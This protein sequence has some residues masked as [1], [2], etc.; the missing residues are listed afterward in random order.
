MIEE[1]IK[2]ASLRSSENTW[3]QVGTNKKAAFTA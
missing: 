2:L 1:T 3:Q